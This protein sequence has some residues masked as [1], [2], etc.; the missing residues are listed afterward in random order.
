MTTL[1]WRLDPAGDQDPE[2]V[3]LFNGK[4]LHPTCQ[5]HGLDA[6]S[7][8]THLLSTCPGCRGHQHAHVKLWEF[9][10]ISCPK[11]ETEVVLSLHQGLLESR[12][13]TCQSWETAWSLH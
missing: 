4:L 5:W 12:V 11:W 2:V 3:I 8:L 9:L 10:P 6:S 1:W 7:V 13:P